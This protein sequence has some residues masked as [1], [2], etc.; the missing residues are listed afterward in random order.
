MEKDLMMKMEDPRV[1]TRRPPPAAERPQPAACKEAGLQ[2]CTHG[3]LIS[4]S[5][6][7]QILPQGLQLRPHWG[8]HPDFFLVTLSGGPG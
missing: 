3:G 6:L 8:Q 7:E 5:D 4:A 2:S 1:G